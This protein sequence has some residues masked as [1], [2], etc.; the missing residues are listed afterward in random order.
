MQQRKWYTKLFAFS[1]FFRLPSVEELYW[2][3]KGTVIFA[4][5]CI[6]ESETEISDA[7]GALY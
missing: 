6:L 1:I 7:S 2:R 3:F 4:L 5:S